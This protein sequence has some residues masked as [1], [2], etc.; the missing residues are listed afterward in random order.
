V[1]STLSRSDSLPAERRSVVRADLDFAARGGLDDPRALVQQIFGQETDGLD[2]AL[3][4]A[5]RRLVLEH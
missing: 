1:S 5:L 3:H 4:V 2:D